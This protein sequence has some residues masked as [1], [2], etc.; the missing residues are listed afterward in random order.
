MTLSA[1]GR[2][3]QIAQW[4]NAEGWAHVPEL[5][6][7]FGVSEVSIRRDFEELE[8]QGFLKRVHGGALPIASHPQGDIYSQRAAG[9]I[10]EKQRIARAAAALIQPNDSVILDSGSTVAEVARHMPAEAPPGQHLRI[11][12][13][14][15]P[16]VEALTPY[17]E[18]QLLVLG[19]IYLHQYRTVAGPQTLA[20]LGGLH[21]D[22]MF[23]GSDGLTFESGTTTANVLEAEVTR[24]MAHAAD[25]VIVVADS[26]KIGQTGFATVMPLQDIDILITDN[27]APADFVAE[28]RRLRVDIRLV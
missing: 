13:G 4:V 25:K 14:S 7:H 21:A 24:V 26:S 6:R 9:H 3:A 17:P 18:M 15:I 23:M 2:R 5:A 1:A 20:S 16:V 11:I 8:E 22:K 12:T 10:E 19:G 27:G 28:L